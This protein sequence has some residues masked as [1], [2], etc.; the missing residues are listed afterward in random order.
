M[1]QF[2]NDSSSN[3]FCSHRLHSV[4]YKYGSLINPLQVP[5]DITF[6]FNAWASHII[7]QL[8]QIQNIAS[9]IREFNSV[10]LIKSNMLYSLIF[11]G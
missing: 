2:F 4:F 8:V 7:H 3:Q 6:L 11:F 10:K 9:L 5:N 1:N